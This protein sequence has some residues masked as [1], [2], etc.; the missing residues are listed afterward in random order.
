MIIT[1]VVEDVIKNLYIQTEWK[2]IDYKQS[3]GHFSDQLITISSS[4]P[5]GQYNPPE[6]TDRVVLYLKGFTKAKYMHMQSFMFVSKSA[7]LTIYFGLTNCTI[8]LWHEKLEAFKSIDILNM[9]FVYNYIHLAFFN[10]LASPSSLVFVV[11][12]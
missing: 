4:P 2:N 5:G 3:Y 8:T 1:L 9:A 11:N 7:W 6:G 10:K 12:I